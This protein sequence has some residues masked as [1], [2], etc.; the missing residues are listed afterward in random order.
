MT[1]T[2]LADVL[3]AAGLKVV[4]HDGWK[5]RGHGD[6]TDLD[7]VVWHHD[8]SPEGDSPG[9]PGFM[10]SHWDIAAANC[11]VQLNGTWHLLAAGVSYHAGKVLPGKPGNKRSLGVE[12]DHTTGETWSGVEMLHSLRVG[13]AAILARLDEDQGGLHFHKTICSPVGRKTDPDGLELPTER[14][15]IAELLHPHQEDDMTPDQARQLAEIHDALFKGAG[16]VGVPPLRDAIVD[17]AYSVAGIDRP[18][19]PSRIKQLLAKA[20]VKV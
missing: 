10:L 13:T 4:E 15:A 2:W 3:R 16:N 1:A 6:F 19:K 11:W 7:S 18:G 8:G 14:K 9:V 17:I 5:D 12:T 20:G